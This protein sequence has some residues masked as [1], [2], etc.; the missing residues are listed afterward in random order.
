LPKVYEITDVEEIGRGVGI[1]I[2][3]TLL[4]D[5]SSS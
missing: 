5:R 1:K 2:R 4:V 3:A